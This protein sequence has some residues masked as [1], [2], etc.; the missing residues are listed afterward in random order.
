MEAKAN[1]TPATEAANEEWEQHYKI[2]VPALV[3]HEDPG[4]DT[5][6][7]AE[8]P[9]VL[10]PLANE[11]GLHEDRSIKFSDDIDGDLGPV[12]QLWFPDNGAEV[13]NTAQTMSTEEKASVEDKE[14]DRIE[15]PA[16]LADSVNLDYCDY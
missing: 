5:G 7:P 13:M 4:M 16:D 2:S 12:Q 8:Q 14:G 11:E 6:S 1:T 9:D 15:L 10:E 3:G